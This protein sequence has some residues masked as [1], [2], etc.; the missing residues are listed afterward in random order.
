MSAREKKLCNSKILTPERSDGPTPEI[1]EHCSKDSGAQKQKFL[2][3]ILS[4]F[5]M[6]QNWGI[7]GIM[8]VEN[9]FQSPKFPNFDLTNFITSFFLQL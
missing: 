4:V 8:F 1:G 3:G 5:Y 6:S 9:L 7:F 2:K